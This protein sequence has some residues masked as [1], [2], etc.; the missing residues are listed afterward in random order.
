MRAG[1]K[2]ILYDYVLYDGI[3][4]SDGLMINKKCKCGD[5]C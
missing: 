5:I 2:S 4:T 1:I 3:I